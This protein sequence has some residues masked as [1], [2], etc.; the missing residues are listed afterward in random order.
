MRQPS[1]P[2]PPPCAFNWFVSDTRKQGGNLTL[3]LSDLVEFYYLWKKTPAAANQRPHRRRHRQSVLRRIRT[4]RNTRA[5]KEEPGEESYLRSFLS[6]FT[7]K[8]AARSNYVSLAC[9]L[10]S[11][12]RSHCRRHG[13]TPPRWPRPIWRPGSFL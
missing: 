1:C 5:A 3:S 8:K 9:P 11:L 10:K 12:I 6:F 2:F 7:V 13:A 4:T